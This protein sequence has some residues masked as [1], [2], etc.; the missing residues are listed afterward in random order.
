MKVGSGNFKSMTTFSLL[1]EI[2]LSWKF[3]K[4]LLRA[5]LKNNGR[6]EVGLRT[7]IFLVGNWNLSSKYCLT[8]TIKLVFYIAWFNSILLCDMIPSVL[9]LLTGIESTATSLILVSG[10]IH[11]SQFHIA[12]RNEK[13]YTFEIERSSSSF[14]VDFKLLY[15]LLP[16][17]FLMNMLL[18]IK[19]GCYNPAGRAWWSKEICRVSRRKKISLI[20]S[21]DSSSLGKVD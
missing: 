11:S 18:L 19:D 12:N 14:S 15:L 16:I 3:H 2:Y 1:I 8:A 6:R 20:S 13:M 10:E 4:F 21:P 9:G 5:S 17:F 7:F